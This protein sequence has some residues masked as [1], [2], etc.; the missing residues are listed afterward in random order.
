MDEIT[1]RCA[2]LRLSAKESAEVEIQNSEMEAGPILVG[3]FYTKRWVNLESVARVLRIAWK[4]KEN[5]EGGK[6]LMEGANGLR[7]GT[8]EPTNFDRD[9]AK[10]TRKLE[11][12]AKHVKLG[13]ALAKDFEKQLAK[14]DA[15]IHGEASGLMK[16]EGVVTKV[17][18]SIMCQD[19]ILMHVPLNGL[20]SAMSNSPVQQALV[21]LTD[22]HRPN[23]SLVKDFISEQAQPEKR[24][25]FCFSQP[26]TKGHQLNENTGKG[27]E[28]KK[29]FGKRKREHDR[30]ASKLWYGNH[31]SSGRGYGG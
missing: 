5:F 27:L 17:M 8:S 6:G 22:A 13:L 14:I 12:C 9:D 7:V 26:S 24:S 30:G 1:N 3:K 18:E 10:N 31:D 28:K 23:M 21:G 19:S 16:E 25:H 20:S 2:G 29:F 4:T 11:N 15:G